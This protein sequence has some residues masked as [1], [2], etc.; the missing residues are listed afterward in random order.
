MQKIQLPFRKAD[1]TQF[2][3][4][5]TLHALLEKETSGFYLL[6]RHDFW[7]GGVHFTE[8]TAPQCLRQEPLRCIADG[9][10]VAYRIN[11]DYQRSTYEGTAQCTDLRYSTSF[12]LVRHAF[13][14]AD[15]QPTK[16]KA[17]SG[18]EMEQQT[19]EQ[20]KNTLTFYSLYMHLL[21]FDKHH[22]VD[23]AESPRVK[24][25]NGGW[26]ARNLPLGEEGSRSLGMISKG[27]EFEILERRNTRNGRYEFAKGRIVKGQVGSCK[28]GAD[29][30]FAI[31]Q[32]GKSITSSSGRQ[33]LARV[34]PTTRI[35]PV[36]WQ[37]NVRGIVMAPNGL[38]VYY[39]PKGEV[40]RPLSDFALHLDS[41]V[42]FDSEAI[43]S[44]FV[45]GKDV[46]MAE[47]TPVAGLCGLRGE[48]TLPDQFWL[49]VDGET[50]SQSTPVPKQ[51]DSVIVPASPIPIKAGNPVG[52][53]GLYEVPAGLQGGKRGSH[54][55]H[56]ELFTC[57]TKALDSFLD[58]AAG[59]RSGKQYL[60][61]PAWTP[62]F[63]KLPVPASTT[64]IYPH[65]DHVL[66]LKSL[67]IYKD[68]RGVEWYEVALEEKGR[69][70]TGLINKAQANASPAAA[71]SAGLI[72]QH[73]LRKLG[74]RTVRESN[75]QSSGYLE[76][77]RV[78]HFFESLNP[79]HDKSFSQ[80]DLNDDCRITAAE[81]KTALSDPALRPHWSK[82]IAYHP[83]EWQ[84]K[85]SSPQRQRF[86][87]LLKQTPEVLR[88]ESERI[89]KLVFWDE[90][91]ERIGLPEDGRVWHFHPV[92]FLNGFTESQEIIHVDE[93]IS[94]YKTEHEVVF[95]AFEKGNKIKVRALNE[96]SERN[97]KLLLDMLNKLYYEYFDSV[98]S[99]YL[100]YMLATV[101]IES[102]DWKNSI[103]FGMI[104]EGISYEK[105]E[106]DYGSGPTG[107]RAD[108]AKKYGNTSIGDGYKYRGRGLVQ[109]T[110]KVNYQKFERALNLELVTT[111]D[112]A[113]NLE[114]ATRI[115]LLGMRDGI[116]SPGHT[117]D[118]HL[119]GMPKDFVSARKI[120]NGLDRAE[121]F[122]Y[123]AE[124]F[125]DILKRTIQ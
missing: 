118:S 49:N 78:S 21:P 24:V 64:Q 71:R 36:Y 97:L 12:C 51:F 105:A 54:Q 63:E 28:Q 74:W 88:H 80:F 76:P 4:V 38:Q 42:E 58:N 103:Y 85:S 55:V 75:P 119:S 19:A 91:A 27:T 14:A 60:E 83:T 70:L 11:R 13:E 17:S 46:K 98:E 120:I 111:P 59:L 89:D 82:L 57:D 114:N 104:Q 52:Y 30:W 20:K 113:L 99:S 61:I 3:K 26:P 94:A 79:A 125:E 96:Q 56:L 123:Y 33:R 25:I 72:S 1:G 29:V 112:L 7:H 6:S 62:I 121:E 35:A 5:D 116:F 34:P 101:R 77:D 43:A 67:A 93:F 40:P 15:P 110:W 68:K 84:A 69:S 107:R 10:V 108:I 32:N 106:I 39:K 48:G 122:A 31:G 90:I 22:S 8:Q 117:L 66:D 124:K 9:E 92:E 50:L 102:Y 16:P 2:P 65:R 81:L 44:F 73:D 53:L 45:D 86:R 47:C 95:G 100:A 115:M 37:G 23:E 41:Q 18:S 109:I 87:E